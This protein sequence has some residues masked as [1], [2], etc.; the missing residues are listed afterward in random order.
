MIAQYSCI[1]L[2]SRLLLIRTGAYANKDGLSAYLSLHLDGTSQF[3][4]Y[5]SS[6]PVVGGRS[7]RFAVGSAR[8]TGSIKPIRRILAYELV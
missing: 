3:Q 6:Y 2:K 7:V 5:G 8:R 1:V 4:E